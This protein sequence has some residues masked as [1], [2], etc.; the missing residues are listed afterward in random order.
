MKLIKLTDYDSGLPVYVDRSCIQSMRRLPAEVFPAYGA[1]APHE[2]G[3]RTR[4]D[5]SRDTILVRETC[6]EILQMEPC[7]ETT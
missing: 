3:E 7:D 5:T 1:P 2:L 6:K 4:I